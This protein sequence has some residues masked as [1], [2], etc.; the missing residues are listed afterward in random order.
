MVRCPAARNVAPRSSRTRACSSRA[1]EA[2]QHVP[3]RLQALLPLRPRADERP[4]AERDA[5]RARRS[6]R[7]GAA[8]FV[9]GQRQSLVAADLGQGERCR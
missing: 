5:D 9:V 8:E 7:L 6:E 3:C 2:A 1:G 4:R